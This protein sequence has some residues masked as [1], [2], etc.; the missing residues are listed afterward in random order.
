MVNRL[1]KVPNFEKTLD[2]TGE[3]LNN[4]LNTP[5]LL[6]H[7][8]RDGILYLRFEHGIIDMTL[9]LVNSRGSWEK[10]TSEVETG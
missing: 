2:K 6:E 3:V 10:I 7:K 1:N 9:P 8:I 4:I 5:G